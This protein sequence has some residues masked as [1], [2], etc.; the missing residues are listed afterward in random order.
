[1]RFGFPALRPRVFPVSDLEPAPE[2]TSSFLQTLDSA[3][4]SESSIA[5]P[6]AMERPMVGIFVLQLTFLRIAFLRF[7]MCGL[8]SGISFS[9][10]RFGVC[11]LRFA[12]YVVCFAFRDLEFAICVLNWRF[13]M[14]DIYC[15]VCVLAFLRLQFLSVSRVRLAIC[16]L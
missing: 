9:D 2:P 13:A 16:V 1:M 3:W 11:E 12:A 15:D 6:E 7:A 14:R 5:T 4:F 8:R 10:L